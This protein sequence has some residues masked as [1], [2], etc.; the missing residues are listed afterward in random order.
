MV[1][2]YRIEQKLGQGGMGV[3]YKAID[4]KLQR[5][6]AIKFLLGHY[7]ENSPKTKRFWEEAR[8]VAQL[9][10]GNI[11]GIHHLETHDVPFLVMSYIDGVS[12]KKILENK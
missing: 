9:T 10:H 5:Y 3:V 6:V 1:L 8:S 12:L 4:T 7:D 2:H 11:M